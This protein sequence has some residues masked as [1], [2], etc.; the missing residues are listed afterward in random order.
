MAHD[1]GGSGGARART[2][3]SRAARTGNVRHA[4]TRWLARW[5]PPFDEEPY[6]KR[7]TAERAI[8][9]LAFSGG[10]HSR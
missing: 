3:L 10:G 4:T 6:E 1:G 7:K 5:T 2:A 9:R 8:N